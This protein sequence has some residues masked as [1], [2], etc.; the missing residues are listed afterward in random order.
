[1]NSDEGH[2]KYDYSQTHAD[3]TCNSLAHCVTI[4]ANNNVH[5]AINFIYFALQNAEK[6]RRIW[7]VSC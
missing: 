2:W 7:Y 1:M 6:Y 3:S 4:F 5:S